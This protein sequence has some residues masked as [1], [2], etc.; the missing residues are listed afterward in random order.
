MDMILWPFGIQ[1][2]DTKDQVLMTAEV[3]SD[4]SISEQEDAED[5]FRV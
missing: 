5:Q 4:G 3:H 2:K 1:K